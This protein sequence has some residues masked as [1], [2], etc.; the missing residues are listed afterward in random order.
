MPSASAGTTRRW[1][2][3]SLRNRVQR[4]FFSLSKADGS[5]LNPSQDQA[6]C[7]VIAGRFALPGDPPR[8]CRLPDLRGRVAVGAG[9]GRGLSK[10]DPGDIF[11]AETQTLSADHLPAHEHPLNEIVYR[12]FGDAGAMTRSANNAMVA[13]C[14]YGPGGTGPCEGPGR[15]GKKVKAVANEGGGQPFPVS[16]PSLVVNY[17][18]KR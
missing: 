8:V 6:L 9:T 16:Q 12:F 1:P 13:G 11:G 17:I 15:D 14:P 7:Q 10:R 2:S 4:Y 5:V 3:A 18:V